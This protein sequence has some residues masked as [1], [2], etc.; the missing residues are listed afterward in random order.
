MCQEE[1]ERTLSRFTPGRVQEA[2]AD[3]ESSGQAQVVERYGTRF[4]SAAPSRYPDEARSLAAAPGQRR[5]RREALTNEEKEREI[6]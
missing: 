5:H 4:W 2:L 6:I 1:L 3:L